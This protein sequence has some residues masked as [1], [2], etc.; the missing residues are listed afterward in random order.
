MNEKDPQFR[1]KPKS[2][3]SFFQEI[4]VKEIS[5]MGVMTIYAMCLRIPRDIP[6][7]VH[8]LWRTNRLDDIYILQKEGGVSVYRDEIVNIGAVLMVE[9]GFGP[10]ETSRFFFEIAAVSLKVDESIPY[11]DNIPESELPLLRFEVG[12]MVKEA[13]EIA[14]NSNF[15]SKTWLN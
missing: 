14:G 4:E 5:Q 6:V 15:Q 11:E 2:T 10:E 1:Q 12:D 3:Y 7:Y 13:S 8:E 9:G